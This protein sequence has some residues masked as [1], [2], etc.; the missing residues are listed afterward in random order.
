MGQNY[1]KIISITDSEIKLREIVPDGQGGW[2][3]R[4]TTVTLNE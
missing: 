3:E 2:S 4:V 1:G